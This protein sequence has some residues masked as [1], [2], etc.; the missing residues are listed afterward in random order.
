MIGL[1]KVTGKLRDDAAE[2]AARTVAAA[3]EKCRAIA[4]ELAGKVEKLR[5]EMNAEI[6]AEGENIIA[7]AKSAAATEKRN[8][9]LAAKGGELD[10]VFGAVLDRIC[11]QERGEYAA[12]LTGIAR[13]PIRDAA[14]CDCTV[15]FNSRDRAAVSEDVLA[16]LRAEFPDRRFTLDPADAAIAGGM[17]LDFGE[18]DVDCSAEVIISQ[19]RPAFEG[20]ACRRLFENNG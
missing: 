3:E 18:I 20:E 14:G 4:D 15:R 16:A 19:Y 8:I 10:A 1:D 17:L 2:D 6:E 7:R 5:A 9:L 11:N 13:G 12:F